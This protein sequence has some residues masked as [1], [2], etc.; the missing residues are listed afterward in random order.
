MNEFSSG[1]ASTDG[2]VN[3]YMFSVAQSVKRTPTAK[4]KNQNQSH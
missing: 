2:G 3:D 4:S 1:E